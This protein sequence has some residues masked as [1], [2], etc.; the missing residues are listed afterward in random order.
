MS[1]H[2]SFLRT[3]TRVA[4]RIAQEEAEEKFRSLLNEIRLLG[5]SMR[6][7]PVPSAAGPCVDPK[8]ER[9]EFRRKTRID[10]IR[11][12]CEEKS[13][14][15][16]FF[17]LNN[18]QIGI[19]AKNGDLYD[20]AL[21]SKL[22]ACNVDHIKPI[23]LGGTNDF[24]NLCIIPAGVNS[25][26]EHFESMQ[27]KLYPHAPNINIV[28]PPRREDGTYLNLPPLPEAFYAETNATRK[29]ATARGFDA[30]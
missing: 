16:K 29:L 26:K 8:S 13:E 22:R 19:L 14:E 10:F 18:T 25:L 2:E 24:Q 1:I 4:S 21:P 30:H 5:P 7:L 23:S 20:P 17:G 6:I 11:W 28:V 15:L 9:K 3:A 27:R 12:I